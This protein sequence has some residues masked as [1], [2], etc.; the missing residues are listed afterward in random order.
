MVL[1]CWN[2]VI[3]PGGKDAVEKSVKHKHDKTA[4]DG[5]TRNLENN[6]SERYV[7]CF[8]ENCHELELKVVENF[9]LN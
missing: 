3:Q 6:L 5:K 1:L 4:S 2:D 9:L 7:T 8:A